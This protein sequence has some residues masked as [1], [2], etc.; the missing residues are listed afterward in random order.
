[1]QLAVP[2]TQLDVASTTSHVNS[3][4][5]THN[6]LPLEAAHPQ[7]SLNFDLS[8]LAKEVTQLPLLFSQ[9]PMPDKAYINFLCHGANFLKYPAIIATTFRTTRG[10][11]A[12]TDGNSCQRT[13]L[14]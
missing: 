8:S 6:K 11:Q 1:M 13:P 4:Q 7:F 10:K 5:F 12:L 9:V 14:C 3:P 2:V